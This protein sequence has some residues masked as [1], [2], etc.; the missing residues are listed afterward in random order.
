[1]NH[2]TLDRE[3]ARGLLE[4]KRR[5]QAAQ[6]PP[7]RLDERILIATWNIREFGKKKRQ[8]ASL[9]HIAEILGQFDLVAIS[10]LRDDV[11]ELGTVLGYLGPQWGVVFSDYLSDPGGNRERIAFIYDKRAARFTGFASQASAPRKKQGKEYLS[12]ESFWRLPYMASFR[13][14]SFDFIVMGVHVRWGDSEK[15]RE[16]E[17]GLLAEW[18][19]SRR[20]ER[21]QLDK[22]LILLGDF[23]IPGYSS[24]L[25][26]AVTKHGLITPKAI[27]KSSIGSNL[28]KDK[29]YDQILLHP[30]YPESFVPSGGVLDFYGTG[31]AAL[32][33]G[34]RLS[35]EAFTYELSDHLPIWVQLNTDLEGIR[36]DQ[37]VSG[38]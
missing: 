2:G 37:V 35:K 10:E 29:R 21:F 22:D 6:I 28:A 30:Q 16:R 15:A 14:G 17:L 9:H 13:A 11:R 19:E 33:P 1:M 20:K 25:Y 18:V 7:S 27:L 26:K 24:P 36:L 38:G 31:H 5:I 32:Y 34:R 12:A 8:K 23:N 3:T 4:L